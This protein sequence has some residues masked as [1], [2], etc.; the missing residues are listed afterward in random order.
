MITLD[1][2][3][4]TAESCRFK[5]GGDKMAEYLWEL[6]L[7]SADYVGE[8]DF[9]LT[10][11]QF[12]RRLLFADDRGFVWQVKFDTEEQASKQ[13][14]AIEAAYDEWLGEE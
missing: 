11:T 12:G 3:E 9:D 7:D 5:F 10:A 13:M 1:G 14:R 4:I 6:S 2:R 8:A